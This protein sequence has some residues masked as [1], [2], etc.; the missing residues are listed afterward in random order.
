MIGERLIRSIFPRPRVALRFRDAWPLVLYLALFGAVCFGLELSDTLV[1]ARP[2]AFLLLVFTPWFW[3]MHAT[4]FHGLS[5]AR[6]LAALFLRLVLVSLFIMILAEPRAVRSRDVLS[7]VY[8]VDISDSI[9]EGSVDRA[10]E[11][12]AETVSR[13]PAKDE[14]GLIVFGRNA[15]VELPPR[16][17]FPFEAINSRID[18][19][20]TNLE[21]SLS[22]SAAM[23]PAENRGRIVLVSDG[24]ETLGKLSGLLDRLKSQGLAVDVLPIDYEY[25]REVWV[26]RLDLPKFVKLGE[27][28]EAAIVLS[29]LQAGSGRLVLRENG[30]EVLDEPVEFQP[31]KNRYTV[32]LS[33][34]SPGY[35]EYSAT[36]EVP[37]SEDHLRENNTVLNYLFIE[38][39]GKVLLVH[40]PQ[41]DQRDWRLLSEAIRAGDRVVDV[42][43]AYEF[44]RDSL[45]LLPYDCVIF[46]NVAADAFDAVQMKALHDAVFHL[47]V[48]FLMVG[49]P[50]SFGPGGYHRTVIE[51]ALPVTMDVTQKKV[52]PKGAL[53]IVLHTCEFPQGNTWGKRITKQAIKVLGARD[54]VGVL[55]YD[56]E[57]GESWLFELTPAGEYEKLV[58]KINAAQIGDM[59]SF[60]TTMSMGLRGLKASDAATKHMIIISD[61]DP[62]PPPPDLVNDF[63][64]SKVSV[65]MVAI[66]PHGGQ[67]ISKMRA[68]AGVT[69]GR[70]YFPKDPNQL[71]SIF[72][73][74]SK[75]LRRSMIQNETVTPEA[76]FPSAVLGGIETMPPLHGYVLTTVRPEAESIL[77]TPP[78][79]GGEGEID[80]ILAK[81][82]Y[83]LGA[84]AAFTSDLSPNWGRDWMEWD[85][86]RPL[87]GQ[88][89]TEISRVRRE[90]HLRLW[91]Y[92]DGNEGVLVVEDFHPD[93]TGGVSFL[94][95]KATVS[96]PRERNETIALKQVGPRRYQARLPLWGRGRYQVMAVGADGQREDQAV[97]GFIVPYSPEYLRFRSNP[98]VL[99]EIR[100]KTGGVNLAEIPDNAERA[101]TIYGRRTPRQSSRPVFDWF[102]IAL[103]CLVPL[104]VAVRRIQPDFAALLNRLGFGERRKESTETM[105]ALLERKQAVDTELEARREE[106]PMPVS[107][108]L[109]PRARRPRPQTA[110]SEEQRSPQPEQHREA[111]ATDDAEMSTTERLLA[112][113][114]K[115]GDKQPD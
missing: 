52:L 78:K 79:E 82:N 2:A 73:K 18:R 86:H 55:V 63:I 105:G 95:V 14:A 106:R 65:S 62:S 84:A 111:T 57:G 41:G 12:V 85:R 7:V 32:P 60:A 33:L 43:S 39:E 104:D 64:S 83:G 45:S 71:P 35:Y 5:R 51:D 87:L 93:E 28:Y 20:A 108:S 77:N 4:G 13:K 56:F 76:G 59:P 49:G 80:P 27:T 107:A 16:T 100:E 15:A 94:E 11:F 54:E 46:T 42:Q 6:A 37:Q 97:G 68:I 9:G 21:T 22:L 110:K 91:S 29:S 109:P 101:E 17:S 1:F 74:E 24:T 102:V 40:D 112:M 89:L 38:G 103:A 96:G 81:W 58:P 66:H 53:A 98:I 75:T 67:D 115:R 23:L 30:R 90:G 99:N 88:L 69:G 70:Y 3:W 61:G 36:I 34:R 26:E 114:R 8:A 19:D 92:T 31:G 113:K 25:N 44:P 50:N 10:L 47:G 48:G 72:I